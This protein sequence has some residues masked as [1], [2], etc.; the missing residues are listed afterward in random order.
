[1]QKRG[2]FL[3]LV[4]GI[5]ILLV[6]NWREHQI[7]QWR[8]LAPTNSLQRRMLAP[9]FTLV[10]HHRKVVKFERYLG[11]QRIVVLFFDA[12]LGAARDARV[13]QL[14]QC[15]PA[16]QQAGIHVIA[17][18]D[19][20]P[21]ANEQAEKG[22]GKP[23]PFPLLTDIDVESPVASFVHRRWGRF[24]PVQERSLNGLFLVARDGT[25][26][27]D[28]EGVPIPVDDETATLAALCRGAWP[29]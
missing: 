11:R 27:V 16:I 22:L 5:V 9:R 28:A 19:S 6:V 12:E 4:A 25:V 29:E 10:D 24:D 13:Q 23:I 17:I 8:A 26:P 3:L 21:Y 7:V 2:L 1:M 15:F 18:S 14:I 20:S